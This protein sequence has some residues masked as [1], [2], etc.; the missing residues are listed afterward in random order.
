MNT[1]KCTTAASKANKET[2]N[3][4]NYQLARFHGNATGK[5]KAVEKRIFAQVP[6]DRK[7]TLE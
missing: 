4:V 1:K 2:C 5:Q 6:Y 3:S 7:S